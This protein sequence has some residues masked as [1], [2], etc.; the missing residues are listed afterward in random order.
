MFKK[1]SGILGCVLV[2]LLWEMRS[3]ATHEVHLS[4]KPQLVREIEVHESGEDLK[5]GAHEEFRVVS[6]SSAPLVVGGAFLVLGPSTKR[7]HGWVLPSLVLAGYLAHKAWMVLSRGGDL[8]A[9]SFLSQDPPPQDHPLSSFLIEHALEAGETLKDGKKPPGVLAG[10]LEEELRYE[11]ELSHKRGEKLGSMGLILERDPT[12]QVMRVDRV[13]RQG[14]GYRDGRIKVGDVIQAIKISDEE[15]WHEVHRLSSDQVETLLWAPFSK[16]FHLRVQRDPLPSSTP[17]ELTLPSSPLDYQSSHYDRSDVLEIVRF[18]VK[19]HVEGGSLQRLLTS[20]RLASMVSGY[21]KYIA[22]YSPYTSELSEV[23]EKMLGEVPKFAADS[24]LSFA[25][26]ESILSQYLSELI[27]VFS[28]K[29]TDLYVRKAGFYYSYLKELL[30]RVPSHELTLERLSSWPLSQSSEEL[31]S[32]YAMVHYLKTELGPEAL[33]G[34]HFPKV[35]RK[36]ARLD[37]Q[38]AFRITQHQT[39]VA[40]LRAFAQ[41]LDIHTYFLGKEELAVASA[42][43]WGFSLRERGDYM[44]VKSVR[45]GSEVSLRTSLQPG[46]RVVGVRKGALWEDVSNLTFFDVKNMLAVKRSGRVELKVQRPLSS[47]DSSVFTQHVITLDGSR[48]S[49]ALQHSLRV[50]AYTWALADHQYKVAHVVVPRFFEGDKAGEGGV[51]QQVAR[52]LKGLEQREGDLDA[53][54]LDLRDN[55]GGEIR[56]VLKLAGLF[57]RP[58][59]MILE[60]SMQPY[61]HE[62]DTI[63]ELLGDDAQGLL[64]GAIGG[65]SSKVYYADYLDLP[66]MVLINASSVSGAELLAQAFR[67]H[68]RGIVVGGP[69]SYGKGTLTMVYDMQR[70]GLPLVIRVTSGRYFGADGSSVQQKGVVADV[71]IPSLYSLLSNREQDHQ[72]AISHKTV[73]VDVSES[74]G[75]RDPGILQTLRTHSIERVSQH[76]VL[77]QWQSFSSGEN[78]KK[79][80]IERIYRHPQFN[81]IMQKR[82][83]GQKSYDLFFSSTGEALSQSEVAKVIKKDV[84]LDEA[85]RVMVDYLK[86]L[87][88]R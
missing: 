44:L 21:F 82:I 72:L 17:F 54:V 30:Q 42:S 84:V 18:L 3:F 10:L 66:V 46:D 78:S 63:T 71:P 56:E 7:W 65:L 57:M 23:A 26:K 48:R 28:Y 87:E 81:K 12:H 6:Y 33:E 13:L 20:E 19:H 69:R 24:P 34:A 73:P 62:S 86:A 77:S 67:V 52:S 88:A 40:F 47:E 64:D 25:H 61:H 75:F 32:F 79:E 76:D 58:K 51:A 15:Q 49:S 22:P 36:Y 41:S 16:S 55:L 5:Q 74:Y 45:P 68:G 31:R 80:L 43:T 29:I 83:M 59:H 50:P 14:S 39:Y 27:H 2:G 35:V 53:V 60:Q 4:H 1:T 70:M 37:A 11:K 9:G 8:S 85:L 38:K